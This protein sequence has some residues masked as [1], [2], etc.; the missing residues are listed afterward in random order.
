MLTHVYAD[1]SHARLFSPPSTR[2]VTPRQL[3]LF[4]KPQQGRRSCNK[5]LPGET[6]YANQHNCI[7]AHLHFSCSPVSPL[8]G[9][10][11]G[12]GGYQV[13][14]VPKRPGW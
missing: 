5:P 7:N 6:C 11:L 12:K 2:P 10:V 1:S 4:N 3:T 9:H 14:N 8:T 13:E